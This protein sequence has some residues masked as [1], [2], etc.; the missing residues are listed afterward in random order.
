MAV[1]LTMTSE[2]SAVVTNPIHKRALYDVGFSHPGHT[3]YL[4]AL[5][6]ASR[7][8]VMMLSVPE[9]RVVPVTVHIPIRTC[10]RRSTSRRSFTR[11]A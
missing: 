9:L 1:R 2:A 8:P 6:R 5:T 3:D 4:A 11:R 7:A 10:R